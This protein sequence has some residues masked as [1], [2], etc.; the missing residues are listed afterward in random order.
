M[1]LPANIVNLVNKMLAALLPPENITVTECAEKYRILPAS[2]R[3]G[4]NYR[5]SRTPF[6]KEIMNCFN[7]PLV[8]E[9]DVLGSAQWAKTTIMEN[10]ILFIIK[11]LGG[12]T[13]LLFPTLD[14]GRRFSKTRLEPMIEDSPG[15]KNIVAKRKSRDSDNTIL[16]K[17]YQ[18]GYLYII[19]AN[20][21]SGLR[22]Y[23]AP[24]ILGD[25]ID[26]VKISDINDK[27][28]K[29]GDFMERAERAAEPL[30][31]CVRY[32]DFQLR[33]DGVKAV[34]IILTSTERR[35]TGKCLARIA[36]NINLLMI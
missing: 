19:G 2:N 28:A 20:S 35:N 27:D 29:E 24:F 9:C 22:G 18:G 23:T 26:A 16:S 10:I 21:S 31:V 11:I 12:N 8:E 3:E 13:L 33:A 25:D 36:I 5:V 30:K 14:F 32:S 34:S 7:D 4:G 17:A 6:A 15:I 1:P